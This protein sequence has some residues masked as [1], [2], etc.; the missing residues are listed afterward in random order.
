MSG[1]GAEMVLHMW[2]IFP[3]QTLL[4][5]DHASALQLIAL[6]DVID[7]IVV[8]HLIIIE[9]RG[10]LYM[11]VNHF[12]EANRGKLTFSK[13]VKCLVTIV[14]NSIGVGLRF[15]IRIF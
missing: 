8:S 14:G 5:R 10:I 4:R 7:G 3:L 11:V 15:S 1:D 2:N 6:T 9:V 13:V 12:R